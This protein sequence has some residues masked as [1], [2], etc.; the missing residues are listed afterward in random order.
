M[1][2]SAGRKFVKTASRNYTGNASMGSS[3]PICVSS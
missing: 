3:G 1:V 2:E